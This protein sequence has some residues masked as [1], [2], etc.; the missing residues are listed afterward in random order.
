MVIET[1]SS[2]IESQRNQF[3]SV[4]SVKNINFD[5]EA[6]FAMQ[7]LGDPESYINKVA[8]TNKASIV[9]A[10]N[11]VAAIGISLNPASKLAYLVPRKGAICLDI[12]YMGIMHVAQVS[13]AIKWGQARMVHENDAFE[14]RGVDEPPVHTFN[15]FGKDRGSVVGCYV[16]VKT[17]EGDYLTHSMAVEAIYEIRDRSEA[18]KAHIKK[19]TSSPWVTD[20]DE[21]AKKTVVKQASKYW[22][23]R[24]QL[25]GVVHYLNDPATEGIDFA[26]DIT[27]VRED[28]LKSI[29]HSAVDDSMR[30]LGMEEQTEARNVAVSIRELLDEGYEWEAFDKYMEHK[31]S[32]FRTA[33][34]SA[35][36][37]NT[38]KVNGK[39]ILYRSVLT[40]IRL[41]DEN[42]ERPEDPAPEL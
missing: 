19:G 26:R 14:L 22:P 13:G 20:F 10:I 34:W 18:W 8:M 30:E 5:R 4:V 36:G 6:Q 17:D 29:Q 23:R 11:N 7:I 35:L 24:E 9:A 39:N 41:A 16:V 40:K 31:D 21:M 33:I 3:N 12:S 28:G 32:D 15:P 42:G 37:K 27:P 2:L 25:D 38:M 1:V